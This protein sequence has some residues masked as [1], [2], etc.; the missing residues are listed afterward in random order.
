MTHRVEDTTIAHVMETLIANGR[1]GM[2]EAVFNAPDRQE[3]DR[4]FGKL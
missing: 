1:D 3:A 2:A 4:L